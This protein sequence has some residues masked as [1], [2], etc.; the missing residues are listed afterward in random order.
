MRWHKNSRLV[1]PPNTPLP[2]PQKI[3][4]T[5]PVGRHVASAPFCGGAKRGK[6]AYRSSAAWRQGR[7]AI[8]STTKRP[9]R[10][11]GWDVSN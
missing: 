9:G 4:L 1:S 8:G 5:L 7:F 11:R 2:P 10:R 6:A 3:A